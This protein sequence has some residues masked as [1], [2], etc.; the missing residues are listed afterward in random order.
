MFDG[1]ALPTGLLIGIALPIVGFLVLYGLFSALE[2]F[3][4]MSSEGFRPLFR[5]RTSAI[6]AIA[7]NAL[8]L[9]HYQKKRY[10]ETMRGIVVPTALYVVVWIVLFWDTIF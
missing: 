3:N 10:T 9:N 5:E 2:S 8:A 6:V 1:N 7:L 4:L